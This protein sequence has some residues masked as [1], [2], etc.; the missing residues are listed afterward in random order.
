M[1]ISFKMISRSC[2]E[3]NTL[4]SQNSPNFNQK[5]N[6]LPTNYKTQFKNWNKSNKNIKKHN[7]SS[8]I[9]I[10]YRQVNMRKKNFSIFTG[11]NNIFC[12]YWTER[13]NLANKLIFKIII[14]Y[15]KIWKVRVNYCRKCKLN[16]SVRTWKF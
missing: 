8:K 3:N 11:K 10:S 13:C 4:I 1:L 15:L 6:K 9:S 5:I 2:K 7:S 14:N 16:L 12:R